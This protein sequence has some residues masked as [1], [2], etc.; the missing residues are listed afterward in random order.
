MRQ[1][2]PEIFDRSK[3]SNGPAALGELQG[4]DSRHQQHL[5]LTGFHK[6][7]TKLCTEL[8]IRLVAIYQVSVP[9]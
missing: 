9:H 1:E 2:P 3:F 7:R 5:C 8:S 4:V 6:L